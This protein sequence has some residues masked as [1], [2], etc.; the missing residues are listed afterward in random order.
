MGKRCQVYKTPE[1]KCKICYSFYFNPNSVSASAF[2]IF[3]GTF[4]LFLPFFSS[5]IF[6]SENLCHEIMKSEIFYH[7]NT[8]QL[9]NRFHKNEASA[10]SI[11]LG[12]AIVKEICDTYSIAIKYTCANKLHTIELSF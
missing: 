1:W 5:L 8:N 7:E 12:L 4:L 3:S 2:L 10:E 9:F 11:G 6:H